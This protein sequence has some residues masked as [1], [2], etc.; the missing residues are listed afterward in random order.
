[1]GRLAAEN[2][3][4]WLLTSWVEAQAARFAAVG[5]LGS[6]VTTFTSAVK[7]IGFAVEKADRGL[8]IPVLEDCKD[9]ATKE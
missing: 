4:C 8:P 7:S 9:L 1:M 2:L 6:L 5:L 3:S